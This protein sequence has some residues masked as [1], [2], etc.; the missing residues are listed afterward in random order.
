MLTGNMARNTF[1]PSNADR[2]MNRREDG[3]DHVFDV[4]KIARLQA[5][6]VDGRRSPLNHGG[7]E[8]GDHAG[9]RAAWILPG[10]E[11]IEET[12]ANGLE[13]IDRGKGAG[14]VLAGQFGRRVG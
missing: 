11:D 13:A 5:V 3:L 14:V 8:Q 1:V 6:A 2:G 10:T 7:N 9:I 12:Q 4:D